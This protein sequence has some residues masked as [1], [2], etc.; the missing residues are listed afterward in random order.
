MHPPTIQPL[1]D[2]A[3]TLS[4]GHIIDESINDKIISLFHL[5]QSKKFPGILD[6][7]P[8]Y[9]S[10]TVFYDLLTIRKRAGKRLATDWMRSWLEEALNEVTEVHDIPPRLMRVPVLYDPSVAPDLESSSK[11]LNLSIDELIRIHAEKNYRVYLLGFLPGF[12]YMGK[13]DERITLP[14]LKTPRPVAAGSV[15]IADLQTGIYPIE[16]PGGWPVIGRT[17]LK[18]FESYPITTGEPITDKLTYFR[19][20]DDVKFY[21]I[22]KKEYDELMHAREDADSRRKFFSV[23]IERQRSTRLKVAKPGLLDTIQDL[24][25]HGYQYLGVNPTGAMDQYAAKVANSLVGNEVDL[26]LLEL[27]FP[28]SAFVFEKQTIIT[29]T[30]A[31]FSPTINGESIPINHPIH[32]SDNSILQF[33]Q[34][35]SGARAYL[36]VHGGFRI[37]KWLDSQSTN[38]KIMAGG[39]QGRALQKNDQI[40]WI[41]ELNIPSPKSKHG[42]QVMPWSAN[43]EWEGKA[44]K[45]IRVTKGEDWEILPQELRSQII[46][47]EFIISQNADRMGYFLKG[48]ILDVKGADRLVSSAVDFGTLQSL[49]DGQLIILMADHQTTGGYPKIAHV[50]SADHGALAQKMPGDTIHFQMVNHIDAEKLFVQH[51]QH[52]AQINYA[53]RLRLDQYIFDQMLKN[54]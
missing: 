49:P 15:G 24:G 46:E 50:I 41:T 16:S 53:S 28:P 44:D 12:A 19:P 47:N 25:R 17:P 21:S 20:G 13:I 6:V 11:K 3:I 33:H 42:F 8:A 5:L 18:L 7:V 10:I 37:N 9:A 36:A 14:R 30:G 51:L 31:D 48:S 2:H 54:G 52:C 4:Y 45:V 23:Q 34:H 1:G 43:A 26:P 40:E 27:H 29:I 22:D 35:R 32:I 38:L 39:Y